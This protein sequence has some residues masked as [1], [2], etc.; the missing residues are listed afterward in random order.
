[1]NSSWHEW[2]C[3]AEDCLQR[4]NRGVFRF[5]IEGLPKWIYR[6]LVETVGPLALRFLRVVAL[7]FIWLLIVFGPP[8]VFGLRGWWCLTSLTWIILAIAGSVWGLRN[9]RIRNSAQR[10]TLRATS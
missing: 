10:G 7:A 8:Y 1:M 2:L 4:M 9:I 5:L 3:H 6:F